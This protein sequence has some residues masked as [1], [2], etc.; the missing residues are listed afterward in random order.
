MPDAEGTV[1]LSSLA[2][3]QFCYLTTAGRVTGRPHTIEIWFGLN[4]RTLYMLSGN[5]PRQRADW[6]RNLMKTPAVGVR[7][8]EREFAGTGRIAQD[9]EEDALARR[10]L[11]EKY[12]PTYSGDLSQ[13][14]RTALPV[15]VDL[16]TDERDAGSQIAGSPYGVPSILA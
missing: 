16:E 2:N 15:A 14:G 5:G 10:L 13:W 12:E 11:L 4:E 8:G 6:V 1:P 7:I 9:A 3:E